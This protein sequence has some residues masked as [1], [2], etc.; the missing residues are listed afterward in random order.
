MLVGEL[1]AYARFH[2][3][4]NFSFTVGYQ[5]TFIDQVARPASSILYNDNGASADPAIVTR[6]TLERF[7]FGGINVSGEF[8][9]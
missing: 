1:N 3:R 8:R 2:I 9:F 5:A 7:D 4:Q 6:P